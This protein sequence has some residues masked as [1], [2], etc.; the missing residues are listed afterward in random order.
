MNR[1]LLMRRGRNALESLL[2]EGDSANGGGEDDDD[3]RVAKA[4]RDLAAAVGS[5]APAGAEAG[6]AGRKTLETLS[7]ADAIVDASTSQH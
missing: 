3:D 7:A 2:E 1:S 6:M 4:A 5:I